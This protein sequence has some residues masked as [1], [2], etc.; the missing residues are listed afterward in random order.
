ME[1]K[2]EWKEE[3]VCGNVTELRCEILAYTGTLVKQTK[4]TEGENSCFLKN[5]SCPQK[6]TDNSHP[7][8]FLQAPV[9]KMV[10]VL[11]LNTR[12]AVTCAIFKGKETSLTKYRAGQKRGP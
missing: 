2:C 9:T 6:C 5:L 8:T 4:S 11:V 3:S 7:L 10:S 1:R 12:K